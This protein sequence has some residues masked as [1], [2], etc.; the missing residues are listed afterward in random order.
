MKLDLTVMQVQDIRHL[1]ADAVDSGEYYG[2]RAQ[3]TK[4][5]KTLLGLVSNALEEY[6]FG[7][8]KK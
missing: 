5:L 1:V 7:A 4:R 3:Y 6:E 2:N 8:G